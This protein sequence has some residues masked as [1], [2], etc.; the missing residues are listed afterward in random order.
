MMQKRKLSIKSLT[1]FPQNPHLTRKFFLSTLLAQNIYFKCSYFYFSSCYIINVMS[2]SYVYLEIWFLTK[3]RN[4]LGK[5][6]FYSFWYTTCALVSIFFLFCPRH[7]AC[8][9]LAPNKGWNVCP[10]QWKHRLLTNGPSGNSHNRCLLLFSHEVLSNSLHLHGLAHEASLS[11]TISQSLLKLMSIEL[12]CHPIISSS[13]ALFSACPQSFP[14]SGSFPVS[15][16]Y[17][18]TGQSIG[19]SA[20]TSVPL[21][22]IQGWFPLGLTGLISLQSKG[23]LRVFSS[24]TVQKYEFFDA[25]PPLWSNCLIHTWLLEKP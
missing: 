7:R 17:A 21:M 24:T 15:W 14:A 9:I 16:L 25:Q 23:L 3:L 5:S 4:N 19:A 11:F 12:V 1:I 18:S 10:P 22:N 8:G 20:A 2:L 13:V 6:I